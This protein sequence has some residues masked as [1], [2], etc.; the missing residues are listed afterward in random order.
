M[1][2]QSPHV[3][4]YAEL[5][6][7]PTWPGTLTV[8]RTTGSALA[9]KRWI[10]RTALGEWSKCSYQAGALFHPEEYPIASLREL[11]AL[12]EDLSGDPRTFIVRGGLAPWV[13]EEIA[14]GQGRPIRRRKLKKVMPILRWSKCRAP[15]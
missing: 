15:G 8:L 7:V 2:A 11:G 3:N 10:W 12:L 6:S 5:R 9:T 4:P 1:D 13:R 14:Q